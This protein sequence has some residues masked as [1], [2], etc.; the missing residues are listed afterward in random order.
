MSAYKFNNP[1]GIY[2]ITFAVVQ[3]VDAFTRKELTDIVIDSL[4]FCQKKKGLVIHGWCLMSNHLHLIISRNGTPS[5]SDIMR[6]FKK[7]TSGQIIQAVQNIP[8]SRKNWMMWLFQSAGQKN[9]NNKHYQFWQQDN[10]PIELVTNQFMEQKLDY[11]H[12]NPV[13]AMLVDTP[14]HYLLSSARDYAGTKGLLAID[15]L[16]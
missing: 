7:F 8:E 1:D 4:G 12:Q 14:E 9:A 6:D 2:F 10:H 16:E 11:I 3:W 15:F 13:K 5:F